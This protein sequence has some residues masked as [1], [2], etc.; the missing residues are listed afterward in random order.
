MGTWI[1]IAK[2]A[3]IY[4]IICTEHFYITESKVWSP[5][6]WY[7]E[8]LL[9]FS[10]QE[11]RMRYRTLKVMMKIRFMK[12]MLML[13]MRMTSTFLTILI[14]TRPFCRW[15][16]WISFNYT[17]ISAKKSFLVTTCYF[18]FHRTGNWFQYKRDIFAHI[19]H[20]ESLETKKKFSFLS[21]YRVGVRLCYFTVISV[22]S[23]GL[24][25][26]IKYI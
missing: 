11:Q 19:S 24:T 1:S 4:R 20:S 8:V 5:E 14:T 21:C 7:I 3:L 16:S 26:T 22:I 13:G 23:Q 25:R 12:S 9:C 2:Y 18:P 15:L 17:V 6:S 10:L